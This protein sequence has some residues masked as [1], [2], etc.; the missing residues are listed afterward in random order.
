MPADAREALDGLVKA[1]Q[2]G[3]ISR[4]RVDAS[5]G[6]DRRPWR[7]N[8]K[9]DQQAAL[10]GLITAS[11]RELSGELLAGSLVRQGNESPRRTAEPIRP[12][13]SST[14]RNCRWWPRPCCGPRPWATRRG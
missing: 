12:T 8:T 11:E 13:T 10:D 14:R 1:V 3:R 2:S 6:G 5:L 9:D 4:E 7:A